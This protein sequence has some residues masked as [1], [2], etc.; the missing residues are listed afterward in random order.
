MTALADEVLPLIR[1]RADI[2]SWRASN[3]HGA[4]MEVAVGILQEAAA[5]GDPAEV[6]AVTQKAIASALKIIMRADDSSGIIG[7]AIR[8]LLILHAD[9][10]SP[11]GVAPTKLVDWMINFQFHNDCGFFT[12]DPV[13]YAA[14]MGDVGMA[15]YRKRLG[16][17]RDDLGP[18]SDDIL[19]R[20]SHA[21]ITLQHNDQR[22]AVYDRDV[23]AII[24]THARDEQVPAWLHDAAKALAEIGEYDLAIEWA[25]RAAMLNHRHQ[26]LAAADTWCALVAAHRPEQLIAV[27]LEVFRRWPTSSTASRL[28]ATAGDIWVDLHDEVIDTLSAHPRD[29]V[30]FSLNT[31][32]DPQR[33]WDT[34]HSSEMTDA[35][36]WLDLVKKY[37]KIDRLAVLPPLEALTRNELE[38]V[39][40]GHYRTAARHLKRMRR[41]A[42][43]T[44]R[45]DDV[46]AL[47]EELRQAHR[48]RPRM[49][50]EFDRAGL[51]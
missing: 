35:D 30:L 6:F 36:V 8:E 29:A 10:S 4:Q 41:L 11:A 9:T 27:R 48:N 37:E 26:A 44:T 1:T 46:D 15:R 23:A 25:Q 19:D 12:I 7:D 21:R 49:Q 33:A 40:A 45:A 17:I 14:A 24:R 38:N 22:L 13:R 2:H 47:I 20:Y 39:G 51:P 42:A 3:A 31:L 32:Q 34:A 18:A 43:K 50:A 28:H 16:E 5:Q